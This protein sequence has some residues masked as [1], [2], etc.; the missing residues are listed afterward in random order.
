[1]RH[2]NVAGIYQF[3]AATG[4]GRC[5]YAMELVEGETLEARVRRDGP[6]EVGAALDV[7]AQVAAALV[8]AADRGLIH[9]D[10]K[11][12]NL[13]LTTGALEV[14]VVDFGLAKAVAAPAGEADLTRGG[15]VGTPAY[16]SPEQF[17][18]GT[19]DA[20]ADLYSL[21]VTL[22]YMLTGRAPFAGRT[23]DELRHHPARTDLPIEQLT[24]RRVPAPVVGLVRG[25]LAVDPARRPASARE[26]LDA[27]E[28]CRRR[29]GTGRPGRLL[30]LD[31]PLPARGPASLGRPRAGRGC[32]G[33]GGG[34][35]VVG[36]RAWD[37]PRG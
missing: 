7:A 20:R 12:S 25:L 31:E 36:V 33:P 2:A 13:L 10:L 35:R 24:E 23:L 27:L 1:M 16:A 4:A 8:A 18:H 21:G 30:P 22:W 28:T 14:K 6:L 3:G 34:R 37:R 32:A 19:V 15:F 9:R 29:L 5:F 26:L 17:D 11:P